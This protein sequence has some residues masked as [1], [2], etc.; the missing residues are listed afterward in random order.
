M[1]FDWA[2][3]DSIEKVREFEK[4]RKDWYG[5]LLW[6]T[7]E[8]TELCNHRCI[9]CYENLN[10]KPNYN[11]LNKEK[12]E[13]LINYLGEQKIKQLTCSGGEPLMYPHI[14]DA[15]KL[16]KENGLIVHMI[17]N[18]YFLTK[19]RAQELYKAGLSQVQINIDSIDPA[20]HDRIRGKTD[21]FKKAIEALKNAKEAGMTCVTQTVL[22]KDNE[23]EIIDIFKFARSIGVHRCRVWDIVPAEGR[24]LEHMHLKPVSNYIETLK[25][26]AQFAYETGALNIES[27]DPLFH[28]SIEKR[29]PISG[30]Y[31]PYSI[32]LLTNVSVK[33]DA[34]FC[35]ANRG[36]PIYNIFD[37]INKGENLKQ[38]HSKALKEALEQMQFLN[39]PKECTQC[40]YLKTCKGGC[41]MRRKFA[42]YKDY[43]CQN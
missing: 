2:E 23:N 15:V 1:T 4:T 32:G 14:L 34:Y 29:I 31:C 6:V 30:G 11:I 3:N 18:G 24:A 17:T 42:G 35:C 27:G 41:F 37:V 16:A 28:R 12:M 38:A 21:S 43:W 5:D 33:G 13:L 9:Y 26:I 39:I 10:P 7:F 40:N 22:V 19:E 8:F 36:K 20:K 25:K